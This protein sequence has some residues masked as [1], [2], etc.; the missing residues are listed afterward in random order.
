MTKLVSVLGAGHLPEEAAPYFAGARLFGGKKKCGGIR[1]IA[2]GNITRRLISK[3]YSFAL[4][5]KA[6][7]LLAPFQ[8]GVGVRGGCEALV[9]TVRALM[10]DPNTSPD[11]CCLLQVDLINAFNKADRATAFREVRRLFPELAR[12]F[13]STYGTQAELIFGEAVILS[14]DGFHQGDPL[15]CLFFALV[16][17]PIILRISAEVPDL[18][19][20]GWFLDDGALMGKLDDLSRAVNIIRQQGPTRGLYLSTSATTPWPKSTIWSPGHPTTDPDPLGHGIPRIQ[21]PGIILLGSPLG[22]HQFVHEKIH[23]K[24]EKIHELTQMLPLIKDPHSEFV[25]L[26]SCFSLPKIVFLMRSTDP[27]QHQDLWATFDDMIRDT[28]NQILGSS[29]NDKQWGQAQLPVAMGGLGLRGAVDHSAG[30]YVSSVNA[31]E[32]LKEGLLSHGNVQVDITN[33]MALLRG[34]VGRLAPEEVAG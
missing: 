4:S 26:R 18:L 30:A 34:K 31:S 32:S 29:I 22:S 19:L 27:T 10:D 15:A 21:D 8:L 20:N 7:Q 23:Q 25:L 12:W 13:E 16:L 24:I 33:A 5:D 28:L 17:H 3:C 11:T 6:A 1:P 9:H 14:C 2:V